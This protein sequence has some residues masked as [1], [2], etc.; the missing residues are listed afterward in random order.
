MRYL[1]DR[2]VSVWSEDWAK[3]KEDNARLAKTQPVHYGEAFKVCDSCKL[4]WIAS[5]VALKG[6]NSCNMVHKCP[7]TAC[8]GST[9]RVTCSTCTRTSCSS[10]MDTCSFESCKGKYFCKDRFCTLSCGDLHELCYDHAQTCRA[11]QSV[12]CTSEKCGYAKMHME[13]KCKDF[14]GF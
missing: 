9:L 8:S 10:K 6:C 14:T 13:G 3:H 4:P 5:D 2:L 11:C 12:C 7:R 1:V